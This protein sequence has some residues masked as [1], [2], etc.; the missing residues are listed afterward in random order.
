MN[1]SKKTMAAAAALEALC[2]VVSCAK[3]KQGGKIKVT[4]AGTEAASTGQSRMMLEVT[5]KLNASGKFEADVQVNGALS[6]DTDNLVTQAKTGVPL[7]V[8]SD[9]G[10]LA[11]QF[12]I[13]DLSILMAP[14]ILTNRASLEKLPE[15]A[16]FTEW[17][18]QLETQGITF[19]ADMYNGFRSFY[20]TSPVENV[21]G[22]KGLRIRGFGNAIGNSLAKYLGFANIGI[23]WGEVLPGIQQ[24][25]L[26]GCEVQV[27]TA[28]GTAIYEVTKNLALTKHYMLQSSFVC[29]SKLLQ[30]MPEE[31]RAFFIKTIREAAQKY[32]EIVAQEEDE[33]YAKM[34]DKGVT[35][36]EVD[37]REFQDA[38][39]P[40]YTNN[41]LKFSDGLKDRLFTELGL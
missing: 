37:L 9:P 19:V 3:T 29:S 4:F 23:S 39:A 31:D 36:R 30:S 2:L 15:T 11:S 35:I 32:G 41:D 21:A 5:E 6:N 40:L 18:K 34:K 24:K 16:I 28:Y 33:Y 10:R 1:F 25:T 14:Y 8:P 27:A 12:N 7:V 17:Q 38:I 26:D 22:L 20:T 13:P